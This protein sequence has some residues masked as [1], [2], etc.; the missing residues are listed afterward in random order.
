MP[1]GRVSKFVSLDFIMGEVWVLIARP[2]LNKL[3][4]CER[5]GPW[6]NWQKMCRY[7][8]ACWSQSSI[9]AAAAAQLHEVWSLKIILCH[10]ICWLSG[11]PGS[12]RLIR[13]IYVWL[14]LCHAEYICPLTMVIVSPFFVFSTAPSPTKFL[15][16]SQSGNTQRIFK[17]WS[18]KI[19]LTCQCANSGNVPNSQCDSY[20]TQLC[21]W[22]PRW[23]Y[24][25]QALVNR[26]IPESLTINTS[27]LKPWM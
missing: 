26:E 18:T 10:A 2:V 17:N 21:V 19:R 6:C 15:G 20:S 3:N 1:C 22:S 5:N 12:L 13:T 27:N 25:A 8:Y 14:H 7:Q 4:L 16:A 11:V 24:L 23:P 9:H